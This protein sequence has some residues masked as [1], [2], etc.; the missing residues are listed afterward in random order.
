LG[1]PEESDSPKMK[2]DARFF[3]DTFPKWKRVS[4]DVKFPSMS[5]N[6][7]DLLAKMLEYNPSKRISAKDAL[8][9]PYFTE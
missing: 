8:Q 6:A 5:K 3:R 2:E 4:F 9:H 7:K 1:T